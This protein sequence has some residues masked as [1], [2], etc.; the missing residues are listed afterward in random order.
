LQVRLLRLPPRFDKLCF[1]CYTN[2]NMNHDLIYLAAPYS[3]DNEKIIEMRVASINR[4]A[5]HLFIEGHFVISPVSQLHPITVAHKLPA[6]WQFWKD[7]LC[8]ILQRCDKLYV[9]TLDGWKES[10]GVQAEIEHA[11]NAGIEVILIDENGEKTI[12]AREKDNCE[13]CKGE[14]GGVKGNEN[15]VDGIVLCDYCSV[16]VSAAMKNEIKSLQEKFKR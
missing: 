5:A 2:N 12:F 3:D 4:I 11:M 14:R 8:N 1:I 9:L 10:T 15:V 13:A 16:S 6:N 7:Y